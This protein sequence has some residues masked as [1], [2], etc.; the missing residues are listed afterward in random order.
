MPEVIG[1]LNL[2]NA[3]DLGQINQNRTLAAISF[4]GRYAICDIPLSNLTNSEISNIG[5]LVN[6]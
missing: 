2:H 1:F 6:R 5:V 3:P 4:L